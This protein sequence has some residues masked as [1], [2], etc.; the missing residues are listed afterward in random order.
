MVLKILIGVAIIAVILVIVIATRPAAFH[1]ERSTTI[2]APAKRVFAQVN[3][4]HAWRAWSPWEGM[5]PDL[6]RTYDGPTSGNGAVYSWS[7]NN[8]VGAGSMTIQQSESP[9][10]IVIALAFLRPFKAHNTATFTFVPED[11]GTRVT[12]AMDGRNTFVTKA[13]HMVMDID[14]LV[15]KDFERGLAAMKTKAE[16]GALASA[17]GN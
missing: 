9:S 6:K 4:F 7:G 5:D 15:G 11:G 16:K 1:I 3:D 14:K 13:F 10:R 17:D 2:G 8:K 12:W